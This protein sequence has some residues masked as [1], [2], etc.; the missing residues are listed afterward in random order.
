TCLSLVLDGKVSA[1]AEGVVYST[2]RKRVLR[3]IYK[4]SKCT[5]RILSSRIVK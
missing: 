2:D 5:D 4:L 1:N 3:F